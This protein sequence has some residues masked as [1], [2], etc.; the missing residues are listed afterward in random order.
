[1]NEKN[2]YAEMLEIPT[3]T[4]N[5]TY[6]KPK[7]SLFRRRKKVDHEQVKE[8]LLEKV[9]SSR[10]PS[11]DYMDT[12]DS[13]AENFALVQENNDQNLLNDE[14][15][16]DDQ[17]L[18]EIPSVQTASVR[19]EKVDKK[20]RFK[21]SIVGVQACVIVGLILT[22]FLT[23]TLY[24]ESGINVFLRSVFGTNQ[25]QKVDQREFSEFVPVLSV[26]EESLVS[27]NNGV[28]TFS[29]KGSVY[30]TVDGKV[31]SI[32]KGDDGLYTLEITHT[33]SFKSLISGL[34]YAYVGLDDSVYYNIPVGYSTSGGVSL[35]FIGSDGS[36]ITGYEII[37]NS[38]I[39]AV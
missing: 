38:V 37:D 7:K 8:S 34:D 3:N 9:N 29:G 12:P 39:W 22:I 28:M 26:E 18:E 20:K 30:S 21:F 32:V 14:N 11:N 10:E 17:I 25:T 2:Q 5:L 31:S 23:N 4:C 36:V 27:V 19:N 15:L 6:V 16:L 24:S 1:M 33:S 13:D 35:C